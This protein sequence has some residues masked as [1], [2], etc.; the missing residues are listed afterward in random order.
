MNYIFFNIYL[1]EYIVKYFSPFLSLSVEVIR[2][3][4][5]LLIL[6]YVYMIFYILYVTK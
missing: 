5:V 6:A 2:L 3:K 1:V 4:Y